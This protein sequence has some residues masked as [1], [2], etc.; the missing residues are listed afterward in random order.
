MFQITPPGSAFLPF[1]WS[2]DPTLTPPL[3]IC[4]P[5]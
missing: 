2:C 3:P 4:Q 1:T 5:V